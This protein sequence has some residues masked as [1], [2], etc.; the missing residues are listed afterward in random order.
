MDLAQQFVSLLAC[1]KTGSEISVKDNQLVSTQDQVHYPIINGIPWLFRNPLHSMVDWSVK[2]NHFNQVLSDEVRVLQNDL[3]KSQGP[4]KQRLQMLSEGK[5]KFQTTVN[6]LVSPILKAKVSS[7]PIYDALSDR[8]PNTQ[9]LLS[10]EANLYRDWVWGDEENQ[11]TCD[12]IFDKLAQSEINNMLVL[13]AGSCRLAYDLH[14]KI[15]PSITIANDINPLLL[16]AAKQILSGNDLSIAEFPLHPR[17]LKNIVLDHQIKGCEKQPENFYLLF[18]DAATPALAKHQF[19]L[20]I[21]PWLIDIQPFELS[22]FLKSIN[23]YLPIGGQWLN[24]GSLVF[25]QNREAL[26]YSIDEIHSIAKKA[27]FDIEAISEHEI[28]YLKSPHNAGYRMENVCCWRAIKTEHAEPIKDLQNLPQW[29]LDINQPIPNTKEIQSFAF[30]H[31]LYAELAAKIDGKKS[32]NQ[33]AKRISR[34]K[35]MDENEA[36]AMVKNFYLKII[37]QTL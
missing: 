15:Q 16:F 24:F 37:Q 36:I 20:L 19:D 23:Y 33:I 14:Q 2:L 26:C 17:G 3:K 7:K 34:E 31:Q 29:I 13:G 4:T 18:S 5:Q 12:L 10:Y 27:G 21:T 11:L 35:A 30:S 22:K 8:A 9:N 6:Q 1:P 32:I 25:N 28:P